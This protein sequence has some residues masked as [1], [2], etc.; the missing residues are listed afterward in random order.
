MKLFSL[1]FLLAVFG[2]G[3]A[4]SP[5]TQNPSTYVL[6]NAEAQDTAA[7]FYFQNASSCRLESVQV[8]LS[9]DESGATTEATSLNVD[10]AP[11][12]VGTFVLVLEQA[13]SSDWQWAIDG[14]GLADC[15]EAG[16]VTFDQVSFG[17]A[18]ATPA[19]AAPQSAPQTSAPQ[20]DTIH[21]IAQ[22]E[23]VFTIA[24]RYGVS[25]GELMD[26][27]DM[28]SEALIFGRELRIPSAGASGDFRSHTVA[29]GDTLF[30]IATSYDTDVALI[31]R[32]NC[33]TGS[34]LDIGAELRIP[35]VG[36]QDVAS[37]C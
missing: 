14:V 25:A 6:G 17:A 2:L 32:A 24:E 3:Y 34:T 10:L 12:Q 13:V 30:S 18:E 19:A 37:G 20:G 21:T 11:A 23:T 15:A 22:G 5:D 28:D 35:P 4:Q 31:E 9:H 36:A 29:T 16:Q 8:R 33:L 1:V 26:Y 27:N 7:T